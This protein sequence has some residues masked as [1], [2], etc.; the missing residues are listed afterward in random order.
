[1]DYRMSKTSVKYT[2]DDLVKDLYRK[3]LHPS[4]ISFLTNK[5]YSYVESL[6]KDAVDDK[7]FLSKK[8][9]KRIPYWKEVKVRDKGREP[10][11]FKSF[12]KIE[13]MSFLHYKNRNFWYYKESLYDKTLLDEFKGALYSHDSYKR[14]E[15]VSLTK[16]HLDSKL[17]SKIK[18]IYFKGVKEDIK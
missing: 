9:T 8:M 4:S 6:V 18:D 14:S 12:F 2:D 1:M 11:D 16:S 7:I 17:R 10:L 15:N 3:G 5:S 13:G